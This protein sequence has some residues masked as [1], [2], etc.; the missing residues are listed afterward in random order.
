MPSQFEEVEINSERWFD[1]T[2]LLNEEF[3]D[4]K[5]FE[6]L[7]QVSN[8]GRVKSLYRTIIRSNGEKLPI[9]EK[10][11]RFGID[12]SKY[13]DTHLSTPTKTKVVKTHRLV[14]ETFIPNLSSLPQVNHKDENKQNNRVDN[15]EWCT[16]KYNIN[17]GSRNK[18]ASNSKKKKVIQ[19]SKDGSLIKIWDSAIDAGLELKIN[20]STI[21]KCCNDKYNNKTSHKYIWEYLKK[22]E[23]N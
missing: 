3:R 11:I 12:G 13:F 19:K 17:Y 7:Y 21:A 16:Q 9:K 2:P 22:E 10:I 18:N 1:L 23:V 20:P 8:Y 6:G 14:A 15:L 4:I 5:G